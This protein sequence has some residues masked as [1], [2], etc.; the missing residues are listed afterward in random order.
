MQYGAMNFPIKPVLDEVQKIHDLGFDFFE[1]TLD[2]PCA[3]Y[4]DIN[5]QAD[6]LKELLTHLG[7]PVVCHLPTFVY[8]ADLAPAIRQTCLDEMVRSLETAARIN[9][10][11]AVLHPSIISG[12]GFLVLDSAVSLAH[13]ALDILVKKADRLEITLCFENM[14]PRYHWFYLPEHFAP[15]LEQYPDL[16]LTLDTGHANMHDPEGNR[17][18]Q[19]VETFPDRIGHVH[20]SDN[21]GKRD[22]HLKTGKGIVDFDRFA[23]LLKDAGFNGTMTF[24]IF[25]PDPAELVASRDHL[26]RLLEK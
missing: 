15:V 11:K 5:R 23:S 9:A 3:H 16:M 10:K 24:E 18:A 21:N 14:Y 19:F 22:E 1:L 20:I 25:S 12:L 6:E 8:T 13:E 4:T 7:M 26:D 2:P 17:L